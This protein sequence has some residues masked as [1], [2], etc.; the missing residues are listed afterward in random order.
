[1]LKILF[2]LIFQSALCFGETHEYG[3]YPKYLG[4][5]LSFEGL[6]EVLLDPKTNLKSVEDTLAWIQKTYPDQLRYFTLMRKSESLQG[7]EAVFPRAIVYGPTSKF[8]FTFNGHSKQ[9]GFQKIEI[10]QFREINPETLTGS[11][12]EFREIDFAKRDRNGRPFISAANPPKCLQCHGTTPR[13][14]WEP[15]E[16]WPGAYGQNDD[17]IVNLEE[18]Y[19]GAPMGSLWDE[20][21][22]ERWDFIKF[23]DAFSTHPRYQFLKPLTPSAEENVEDFFSSPFAPRSKFSN[24]NLRPNLRLTKTLGA[25]HATRLLS[26]MR[27]RAEDFEKWEAALL[28]SLMDCG[29]YEYLKE[30]FVKV[31]RLAQEQSHLIYPHK[32]EWNATGLGTLSEK[33]FPDLVFAIVKRLGLEP[34]E[35]TLSRKKRGWSYFLGKEY[36]QEHLLDDLIP[37]LSKKYSKLEGYKSPRANV[38]LSVFCTEIQTLIEQQLFTHSFSAH[39]TLE[40]TAQETVKMCLSCHSGEVAGIPA[41]PLNSPSSLTGRQ[42]DLIKKRVLAVGTALQ[43]PPKRPLNFREAQALFEYLGI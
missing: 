29:K 9:E 37:H 31:F 30:T 12:W 23:A 6:S 33:Y 35:F 10:I 2:L 8:I 7:A 13:P 28:G 20:L 11:S 4:P 1:V 22:A 32:P 14:L 5:I 3:E 16:T 18:K 36:L 38:D 42:K 19:P 24:Y 15:Y 25:L 40:D 39:D 43:M 27:E 34:D 26:L 21:A 41:L 17:A